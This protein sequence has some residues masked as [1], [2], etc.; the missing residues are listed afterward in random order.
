MSAGAKNPQPAGKGKTATSQKPIKEAAQV[1]NDTRPKNANSN[2]NKNVP[3][4][5]ERRRESSKLSQQALAARKKAHE[6]RQAANGAAD[7]DERQHLMEEAINKGIEAESFGKTAKYLQ[8]GTFQGMAVGTG[9]GAIPGVTLGTLTGTLVGGTVTLITGGI[10]GAV[11]AATG[12][13]HGPFWNMGQL[14]GKGIRKVTG[15]LP[16]WKATD[17]QKATLEKMIGQVNEQEPPSTADLTHMADW[18]TETHPGATQTWAEY[19]ASYLPSM[20]TKQES[21]PD[22]PDKETVSNGAAKKPVGKNATSSQG[23]ESD[24]TKSQHSTRSATKART[25]EPIKDVNQDSK[26][27]QANGAHTQQT[28]EKKPSSDHPKSDGAQTQPTSD[29]KDAAPQPQQKS[30][31]ESAQVPTPDTRKKPRKLDRRQKPAEESPQPSSPPQA[32]KMPRKLEVRKSDVSS[33]P[34][35][36]KPR[37]LEAR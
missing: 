3:S 30:T 13:L 7:P 20:S 37:K 4:E 15:D 31:T 10:G 8:S 33:A 21:K 11:G 2:E 19:G 14:V 18:E 36:K 9:I 35:R 6:L 28:S 25:Q 29:R 27:P 24:Q 12:A 17:E 5:E 1:A 22:R 16:G 23:L 32:K 34:S 26:P